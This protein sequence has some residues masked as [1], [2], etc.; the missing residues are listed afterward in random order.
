MLFKDITLVGEGYAIQENMYIQTENDVIT[1]IGKEMPKDYQGEVYDGKNKV[2]MSG[3]F[4]THCHIPMGLMRGYGEG[5]SLQSWLFDKIFPFEDLLTNDDCYWGSLIGCCEMIASGVTSFSDMYMFMG[6]TVKAVAES[7][8][9]ANISRC[10]ASLL[11]NQKAVDDMQFLLDYVKSQPDNRIKADFSIHA[12]YTTNEE[13]IT[14]LSN[15]CKEHDMLMQIHL[16]ETKLEHENCKQKYGM[17]PAA[18]FNKLGTFD[19]KT[20]A[21]HCVF[22]EDSDLEILKEKGV[23]V[24][25]CPSSNLKLGSGIAPIKKYID[26][27]VKVSIGSDSSASNNNL[28]MLEEINLAVLLQRGLTNDPK[29]ISLDE[30]LTLACKNGALSQGRNDCGEIK[31]GNK[32]DIIVVDMDRPHLQPVYDALTNIIFSAQASDI[33][34]NMV[35]GN[36][37]YKDGVWLTIDYE[38]AIY[39]VKR[40][41]KQ[42]IAALK[43]DK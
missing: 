10:F 31:V 28:N 20:T 17:T 24:A 27:G 38:Q 8:L 25:H 1:Y 39:N 26:K 16:S 3:F 2:A 41:Q 22:L 7:G 29:A 6:G 40:V 34:L 33:V 23:T 32:A 35:D 37:L 42:K 12:E 5:L 36:V 19:S 15:Y 9:K 13:I 14:E 30:L 18:L 4:N 21:A 43:K 11:S